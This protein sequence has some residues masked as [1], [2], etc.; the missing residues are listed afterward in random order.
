MPTPWGSTHMRQLRL[1]AASQRWQPTA[2]PW[3][4]VPW[5]TSCRSQALTPAQLPGLK[6]ALPA[7]SAAANREPAPTTGRL[8][9]QAPSRQ[10]AVTHFGKRWGSRGAAMLLHQSRIP[11]V[12][13][14]SP[15]APKRNRR[16][17]RKPAKNSQSKFATCNGVRGVILNA[18]TR[19]RDL[20]R[21]FGL[22]A[23]KGHG[24][25]LC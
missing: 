11:P 14:S 13:S 21:S 19:P 6:A 2:P 9:G 12:H 5:W 4:T 7:A 8:A 3:M 25:Q 18:L 15:R 23:G 17:S 20:C 16:S 1:S 24:K 10:W 22:L